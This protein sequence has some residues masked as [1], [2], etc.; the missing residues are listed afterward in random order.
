[1]R[2]TY[3]F[4]LVLFH[5]YMVFANCSIGEQTFDE[6]P[7]FTADLSVNNEEDCRNKGCHWDGRYCY[8]KQEEE[9]NVG[10]TWQTSPWSP[11]QSTSSECSEQG[12]QVREVTCECDGGCVGAPPSEYQE[13]ELATQ[14][15]PCGSGGVCHNE[16]CLEKSYSWKVENWNACEETGADVCEESGSQM[17]T[18]VCVDDATQDAVSENNCTT[19]KPELTQTC[20][21]Q[22]DNRVCEG[23]VCNRGECVADTF[24][25]AFGAWRECG[26]FVDTCSETGTQTR[27]RS[28]I[29]NRTLETVSNQNCNGI[30]NVVS[31]ACTRNTDGQNCD[32]GICNSGACEVQAEYYWGTSDWSECLLTAEEQNACTGQGRQTRVV[33]CYSDGNV[34]DDSQCAAAEQQASESSCSVDLNG[35]LCEGGQCLGNTCVQDT[36]DWVYSPWGECEKEA[37]C[38]N[39]GIHTR[40]ASCQNNRTGDLVDVSHCNTELAELTLACNQ[41]TDDITCQSAGSTGTC[42]DEVCDVGCSWQTGI[43]SVCEL[44][45]ESGC[46]VPGSQS[47]TVSCTCGS[48]AG[49]SPETTRA[50][51]PDVCREDDIGEE[52]EGPSQDDET[53]FDGESENGSGSNPNS[54]AENS[55]HQEEDDQIIDV[56]GQEDGQNPLPNNVQVY[57][58]AGCTSAELPYSCLA[59]M[60]GLMIRRARRRS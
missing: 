12:L 53:E 50:C 34:V 21:L 6:N 14:G 28:C 60:M 37:T 56:A 55:N 47:R 46:T 41:S 30:A 18:V 35:S 23:G 31:Q 25:W 29:N 59:A 24:S 36:F 44:D 9:I 22:T 27:S 10:C 20:T 43:W 13:C 17:R 1:M 54:D 58:A 52:N 5:S 51:V 15:W 33:S 48:C 42:L 8:C 45:A 2:T 57:G 3:V 49:L 32:A 26:G 11:C 16:A 4:L 19:T 38:D 40:T 7:E 39:S